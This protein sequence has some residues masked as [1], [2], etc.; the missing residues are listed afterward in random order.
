MGKEILPGIEAVGL[1]LWFPMEKILVIGDVHLGYEGALV[2]QG[3][4]LP[5][6]QFKE[7]VEAIQKILGEVKPQTIVVNGDLKHVFGTI[8]DQEWLDTSKFLDILLKSSKKVVLVKGN[9]DTILSPIAKRKK[10]EIVEHYCF[11]KVKQKSKM[12]LKNVLNPFKKKINSVCIVHGDKKVNNKEVKEVDL[13]IIGH[14]HPAMV[15]EEGSKREKYKCFLL[16]KHKKQK[17]IVMPSFL[18]GILG[19][20]IKSLKQSSPEHSP[21]LQDDLGNFEVFIVGEKVYRF[22]KLKNI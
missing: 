12:D 11:N 4:L 21:Y 15:L 7:S 3:Y 2:K 18:P 9:H 13:I 19:F 8:S 17:L 14:S 22:G 20:D 6:T 10:L 16:G 5:Q 1:G